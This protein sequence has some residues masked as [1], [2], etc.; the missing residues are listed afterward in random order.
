MASFTGTCDKETIP[1]PPPSDH[2]ASAVPERMPLAAPAKLPLRLSLVLASVDGFTN[3]ACITDSVGFAPDEV[4]AALLDLEMR[5]LV[6][7]RA[8]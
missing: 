3:V 1:A 7:M 4:Y 5:G 2:S 8:R 6:R